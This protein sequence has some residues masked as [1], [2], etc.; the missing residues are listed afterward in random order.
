VVAA[1]ERLGQPPIGWGHCKTGG[2]AGIDFSLW[3]FFS[4][5]IVISGF[6]E[7]ILFSRK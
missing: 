4:V 2:Q 7:F 1:S 6:T 5:I 3:N